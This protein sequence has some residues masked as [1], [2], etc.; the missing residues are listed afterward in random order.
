[1]KNYLIMKNGKEED[2]NYVNRDKR[3]NNYKNK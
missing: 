3:I 2:K 1:M